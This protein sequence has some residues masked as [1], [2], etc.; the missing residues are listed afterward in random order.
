MNNHID[1]QKE[2]IK[3]SI[4]SYDKQ[5]Q[6]EFKK[7][8]AAQTERQMYAAQFQIERLTKQQNLLVQDLEEL[9]VY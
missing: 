8:N 6:E 2:M 5:I 3:E 9:S 7:L 1:T 4:L